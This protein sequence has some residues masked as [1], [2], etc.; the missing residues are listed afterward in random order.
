MGTQRTVFERAAAWQCAMDELSSTPW[1]NY[2]AQPDFA[3]RKAAFLP[4]LRS[5]RDRAMKQV[6]LL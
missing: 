2:P 3:R 4:L 6:T 1:A 5:H